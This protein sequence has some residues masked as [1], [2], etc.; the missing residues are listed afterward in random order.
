MLLG[1]RFSS[2]AC[3]HWCDTSVIAKWKKR[4][5]FRFLS[6]AVGM[7]GYAPSSY[8]YQPYAL[9]I[10][11]HSDSTVSQASRLSSPPLTIFLYRIERMPFFLT[12][13]RS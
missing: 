13:L 9:L 10:K 7:N 12:F 5:F 11:L 4:L 6:P 8:G 1:I 3:R 2:A